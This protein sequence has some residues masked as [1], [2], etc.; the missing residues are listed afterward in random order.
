MMRLEPSAWV[1]SRSHPV[2]A[3][4]CFRTQPPPGSLSSLR[5]SG[6]RPT[7]HGVAFG[8]PRRGAA[9]VLRLES[10]SVFGLSFGLSCTEV[11]VPGTHGP[12]DRVAEGSFFA[13]RAHARFSLDSDLCGKG[14][15]QAST[16]LATMFSRL[17]SSLF[18]PKA[19]HPTIAHALAPEIGSVFGRP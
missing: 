4:V 2:W 5:R 8:A 3:P 11:S 12:K 17:G 16:Q 14:G 7:G 10:G 6:P 9:Q 15:A 1:I 19:S 18:W 13:G